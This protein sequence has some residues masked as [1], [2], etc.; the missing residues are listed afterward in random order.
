MH[1]FSIRAV[2]FHTLFTSLPPKHHLHQDEDTLAEASLGLMVQFDEVNSESTLRG[3]QQAPSIREGRKLSNCSFLQS[4]PIVII[5]AS[6][7]RVKI[8][9][10]DSLGSNPGFATYWLHSLH[11]IP[12]PFWA[13]VYSATD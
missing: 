9:E 11:E 5:I 12:E 1:H 8:L 13:L 3:E 6:W 10:P 2:C 4:S 7:S